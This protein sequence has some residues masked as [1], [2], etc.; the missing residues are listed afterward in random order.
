MHIHQVLISLEL[1]HVL[2]SYFSQCICSYMYVEFCWGLWVCNKYW[3]S[4]LPIKYDFWWPVS[5]R[6]KRLY[7]YK[8]SFTSPVH[9][10]LMIMTTLNLPS[11]SSYPL[12]TPSK[13]KTYYGIGIIIQTLVPY[14]IIHN[15]KL[16]K[17][18]TISF[19]TIYKYYMCPLWRTFLRII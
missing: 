5:C 7:K 6:Y 12:I 10:M 19:S 1:L 9:I 11:L 14:C 3:T 15:F 17:R 16:E 13:K 18:F 2:A 8:Y 4:L